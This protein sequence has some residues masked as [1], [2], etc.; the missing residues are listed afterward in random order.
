VSERS[1]ERA[2]AKSGQGQEF[3][4][5]RRIFGTMQRVTVIDPVSGREAS[6]TGPLRPG[7]EKSLTNIAIGKLSRGVTA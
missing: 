5:E 6:A 1:P 4:V 2:G 7:V 3:L